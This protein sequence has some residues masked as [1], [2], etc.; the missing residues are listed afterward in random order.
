MNTTIGLISLLGEENV[1]KLKDSI[2]NILIQRVKYDL[3][4]YGE[5]LIYPPDIQATMDE[6]VEDT[7]TKVRKMYKNAVLDINKGYI[8]KMKAYMADTTKGSQLRH[9]VF[10]LAKEY[11]WKGNEYS[12][13]RKFAKKLLEILRLTQE[14][15]TQEELTQEEMEEFKEKEGE[16]D[17]C[18]I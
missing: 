6:A 7:Y 10:N 1:K 13:E 12:K 16:K 5:Y 18:K 3:D 14:E 11:F 2:T 4:T 8:E 9:E 15:L 17:E